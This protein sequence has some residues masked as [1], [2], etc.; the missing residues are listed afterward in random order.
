[1]DGLQSFIQPIASFASE[2]KKNVFETIQDLLEEIV[3]MKYEQE[4]GDQKLKNRSQEKQRRTEIQKTA[5][6]AK[7]V[8]EEAILNRKGRVALDPEKLGDSMYVHGS[9][10]QAFLS[11]VTFL[12]KYLP[13]LFK[14][15][16]IEDVLAYLV[17]WFP[18][19]AEK[20]RELNGLNLKNFKLTAE[21]MLHVHFNLGHTSYNLLKEIG[22]AISGV[23]EKFIVF[24]SMQDV[25]KYRD[26]LPVGKVELFESPE[27]STTGRVW[28]LEDM[29]VRIFENREIVKSC[30]FFL[31]SSETEE[32]AFPEPEILFQSQYDGALETKCIN[33]VNGVSR[34]HNLGPEIANNPSAL[35]VHFADEGRENAP[36]MRKFFNDA[37][38]PGY[39]K[40]KDHGVPVI[41]LKEDCKLCLHA[42]RKQI[43]DSIDGNA[44]MEKHQVKFTQVYGCDNK[45]YMQMLSGKSMQCYKC[46]TKLGEKVF[47]NWDNLAA[48]QPRTLEQFQCASEFYMSSFAKFASRMKYRKAAYCD[49]EAIYSSKTMDEFHSSPEF[50]EL[51]LSVIDPVSGEM[52][53]DWY[54]GPLADNLTGVEN[55]LIDTLH[56][57]INVSNMALDEIILPLLQLI[58]DTYPGLAASKWGAA[59][60]SS[61]FKHLGDRFLAFCRLK[62]KRSGMVDFSDVKVMYPQG[63]TTIAEAQ[64]EEW[65]KKYL[66]KW[67]TKKIRQ[68]LS[69]LKP[70]MARSIA[71]MSADEVRNQL[72]DHLLTMSNRDI[73][74]TLV[75]EGDIDKIDT[76]LMYRANKAVSVE[77][78]SNTSVHDMAAGAGVKFNGRDGWHFFV[79]GG[80][81]MLIQHLSLFLVNMHI[82]NNE[83][84][85]KLLQRMNNNHEL[86]DT[87][88][89][90]YRLLMKKLLQLQTLEVDERDPAVYA[91]EVSA[92][93]DAVYSG[94]SQHD[95]AS[96]RTEA[97]NIGTDI[98]RLYHNKDGTPL[99]L[100]PRAQKAME[101][102]KA[103]KACILPIVRPC[104]TNVA[105]MKA[106]IAA[107]PM[108]ISNLAA[109]L[110]SPDCPEMKFDHMGAHSFYV[111]WM[112][113][114]AKED[115]ERTLD[116]WGMHLS[117]FSCQTSEHWNKVLKRLVER[118]HGFTHR[119]VN[120]KLPWKNKFGFV[121]HEYMLRF[122]HYFNTFKKK[123]ET[124][125][126]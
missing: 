95:D 36:L 73:I 98:I 70:S 21:Q 6:Y 117:A 3:G 112:L 113:V 14:A 49:A 65:K 34:I 101:V 81:E 105:E 9:Y 64:V 48:G 68:T 86:F 122:L 16:C 13:D 50:K 58:N 126:Q 76:A 80:G 94:A 10:R 123:K 59:C 74:L 52:Y 24:P 35:L 109:E 90:E 93:F 102:F 124:S 15:D 28:P 39:T 121:M 63:T 116:K 54:K 62:S 32:E 23:T 85:D 42:C 29:V 75:E 27:G 114:H 41:C 69:S 60:R 88:K 7:N 118:L 120:P 77:E 96:Y 4:F 79:E 47:S 115:C 56:F 46:K 8:V 53:G 40:F 61:G 19:A 26:S 72:N 44:K 37:V 84:M 51:E 66:P 119:S 92:L 33:V 99:K 67:S 43:V 11:R 83:A 71:K 18:K 87:D 45:M 31:G 2:L 22:C 20:L 38:L 97:I 110:K 30:D 89:A 125:L 103:W 55:Y 106:D 104:S 108:H 1:M 25:R 17:N 78:N 5:T 107:L 12:E 82:E 91:D 100:H 57:L 111:H